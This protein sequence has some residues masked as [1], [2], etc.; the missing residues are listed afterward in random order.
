MNIGDLQQGKVYFLC[1]FSDSDETIPD[2]TPYVFTGQDDT[3][4]HFRDPNQYMISETLKKIPES[5]REQHKTFLAHS[6]LT[7]CDE[8][9]FEMFCTYNELTDFISKIK[10]NAKFSKWY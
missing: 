5:E 8:E 2:I 3:G 10:N 7:I 6:D 9:D 4:F 1:M